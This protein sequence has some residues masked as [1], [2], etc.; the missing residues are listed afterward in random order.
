MR[1][2]IN[3][4]VVD[5]SD[6]PGH[7]T[8]LDSL[9]ALGLTGTKEGCAEGECGACAVALVR[10]NGRGS[11]LCVVNSCLM[12]LPMLEGQEIYTVEGLACDGRLSE[13]QRAIAEAAAR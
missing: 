10:P 11:E 13:P 8:L 7:Y 6:F 4:R 9:R 3:Q 1:F 2:S 12:F 5:G